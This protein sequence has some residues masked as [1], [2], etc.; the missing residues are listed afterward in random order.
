MKKR[1]LKTIA[2]LVATILILGVLSF[3]NS[4]IGN[5]ISKAIAAKTAEKHLEKTYSNKDFEIERV[6]Y[7]FKDGFYHAF[8]SSPNS[9]DSS[10]VLII[11]MW[12]NLRSDSYEDR[13]LS[14]WNTSSRIGN[15]YRNIV[16]AVLNSPSFPY[17][18]HIGYGDFEFYPREHLKSYTVPSYALITEDLELDAFYDVN[19][20][21]ENHGKLT[22][23]IDDAEVSVERSAE[24]L[25]DVKNIFDSAGVKFYIIDFVLEYPKPEDGKRKE[26]RVEIREFLYSDIYEDGLTE[27]IKNADDATKQHYAEQDEGKFKENE[28]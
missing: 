18:V 24:I 7:S 8:I 17:N 23:Y 15:E 2:L 12:G 9:I 3:A 1:I 14:G 28:D 5:P 13:V 16:N 20:L 22:V 4:L 11:D 21:A 19:K 6:F 26:E 27:R 10:F 25:L